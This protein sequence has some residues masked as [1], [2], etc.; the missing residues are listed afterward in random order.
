[1][2][3]KK[4]AG[5]NIELIKKALWSHGYKVKEVSGLG[6]GYDLLVEGRYKVRV[7]GTSEDKPTI[8][9]K[10][11]DVVAI[12]KGAQKKYSLRSGKVGRFKKW[13]TNPHKVFGS[14]T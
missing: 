5:G 10:N 4:S 13:E 3:K 9:A 12:V 7:F 14:E 6:A 11:C 1:M 2:T 8:V